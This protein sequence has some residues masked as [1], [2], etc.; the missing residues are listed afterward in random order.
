MC[1]GLHECGYHIWDY[2]YC[3]DYLGDDLD[4]NYFNCDLDSDSDYYVE[5]FNS[6]YFLDYITCKG[7]FCMEKGMWVEAQKKIPVPDTELII[8]HS[9]DSHYVETAGVLA[10]CAP[11]L[12]LKVVF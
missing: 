3:A 6:D 8:H 1:L 4:C 9:E 11:G 2:D 12:D 5:Y 7:D 10:E